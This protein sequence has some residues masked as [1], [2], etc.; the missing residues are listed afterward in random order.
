MPPHAAPSMMRAHGATLDWQSEDHVDVA[1][2]D[3]VLTLE[4]H[5]ALMRRKRMCVCLA[6]VALIVG[7]VFIYIEFIK[8]KK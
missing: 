1:N 2:Q 4:Q 6:L 3:L 5:E 7:V 8:P